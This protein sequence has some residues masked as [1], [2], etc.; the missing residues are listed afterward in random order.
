[1]PITCTRD[2]T[3]SAADYIAVVGSTYMRDKRPVADEAR[4][5]EILHGSNLIV[6]ARDE[7]GDVVG[8][9]RGMSDGA[10]GCYLADLA[11]RADPQG[12]GIGTALLHECKSVLGP[13]VGIVL[14]A[15]PEAEAFY[16]RIG[17]GEMPAF[18]MPR[19]DSA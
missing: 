7:S 18:F 9:A 4:I 5:A 10:W 3:L 2:H 19:G 16:R 13:R 12:K 1:M 14:L 15:Y 17:L 6:T 8:V 11:V